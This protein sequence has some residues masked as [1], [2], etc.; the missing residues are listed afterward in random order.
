M[1]L[2]EALK[3]EQR[4]EWV[5]QI[6]GQLIDL[7]T[8][9]LATFNFKTGKTWW[10]ESSRRVIRLKGKHGAIVLDQM[11]IEPLQSPLPHGP[12]G[13][14]PFCVLDPDV[15]QDHVFAVLQKT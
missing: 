11:G 10:G 1:A 4:R 13:N 6:D 3:E 5:F 12:H 8:K 15:I 9:Q 2:K 7:W 14:K